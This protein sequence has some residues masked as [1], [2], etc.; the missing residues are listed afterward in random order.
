MGVGV[1]IV[2]V[3]FVAV[4]TE[5]TRRH[6]SSYLGLVLFRLT[7]KVYKAGIVRIGHEEFQHCLQRIVDLDS[8]EKSH[9]KMSLSGNAL[10][11]AGSGQFCHLGDEGAVVI[12]HDWSIK[13]A[14]EKA[15]ATAFSGL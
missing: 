5:D 4:T 6:I 8:K 2:V 15:N 7:R 3:L 14:P 1:G 11:V 13:S 9:L 10:G 12:P